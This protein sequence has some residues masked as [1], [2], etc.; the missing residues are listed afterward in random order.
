MQESFLNELQ[1]FFQGI[2]GCRIEYIQP[3]INKFGRC[4]VNGQ[5]FSSDFN[6]TD[7]G[8]VVKSMFVDDRNELVPFF[9]VVRFYFTVAQQQAKIHHLAYVTWL[10]LKSWCPEPTSQLYEVTKELY[11][12]D[13]ILSPRRFLC[14]CVLVATKQGKAQTLVS[15]LLK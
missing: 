1:A 9:G 7:R 15:E 5:S 13:R 14:R 12:R 11:S 2:Y 4:V 10:K 3:R 6:S 8:S